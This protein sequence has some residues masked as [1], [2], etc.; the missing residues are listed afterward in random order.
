MTSFQSHSQA[1][2]DLAVF[3]MLGDKRAGTFVDIGCS[4]P[5]ELSNTYALEQLGWRGWMLDSSPMAVA[6]CGELRRSTT[7]CDDA[8]TFDWSAVNLPMIV[9]YASVD[10]DEHTHAALLQ[11]L[12]SGSRFRVMTVEHDHYQRGD[13]L[14]IPN[15]DALRAAGYEL[16]AA[17]VESAGCVFEDW[18]VDP[19][20]VDMARVEP[21]R[22]TGL[23]WRA[24]LRKGGAL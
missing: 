13:R 5:I 20:L 7:M 24:V 15:R 10:V 12:K 2:Q 18:L 1:G 22:S 3:A 9:D 21:F 4:H 19:H 23:D 6:L 14:R 16:I 11:L 8:R 17:D